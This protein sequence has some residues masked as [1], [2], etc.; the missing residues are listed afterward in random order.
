LT[1]TALNTNAADTDSD[2]LPAP[3][4]ALQAQGL[5]II[6]SFSAPGG[7]SGY[8][9][10]AN[11]RPL[12][13]Y[14]TAD[15]E[16]AVIGTLIDKDG[17]N[18]SAEPVENL[19]MAPQ[20]KKAWSLLEKESAWVA[21]G[22]DDADQIIYMFD[23]PECPYCHRFWQATRPWVESGQVQ[24][25]HILV[26]VISAKSPAESAAILAA[27][28]PSKALA[29]HMASTG[30]GQETPLD[31]ASGTDSARQQVSK[32]ENLMRAL[33]VS[34]T[35]SI[36]YPQPDGSIGYIGGMPQPQQLA[37][38]MGEEAAD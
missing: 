7:L 6:D 35:P 10:S 30:S 16:H 26:G 21:D 14:V 18:L 22:S 37:E 1:L 33:N 5:Q 31:T 3:V 32:N 28:N 9:A 11:G 12:V 19:I 25:R 4:Q 8:A 20:N 24:I 15:G 13:L 29:E 23:D 27:D 36:Y 2:K 17:N 38:V 34:G